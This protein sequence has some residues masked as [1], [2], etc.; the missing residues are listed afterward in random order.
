MVG[1]TRLLAG[2]AE[3]SFRRGRSGRKRGKGMERA[4]YRAILRIVDT[5]CGK[6]V[7][8][9]SQRERER[10]REIQSRTVSAFCSRNN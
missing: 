9:V 3:D 2:H 10:N 1:E 6:S 5:L 4:Q 8:T 7:E